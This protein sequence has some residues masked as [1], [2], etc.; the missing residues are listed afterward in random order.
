MGESMILPERNSSYPKIDAL[1][2]HDESFSEET[3][4]LS[5]H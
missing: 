3:S 5:F 1:H 2:V 4:S